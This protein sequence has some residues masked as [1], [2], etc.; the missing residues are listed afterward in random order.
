M[1]PIKVMQRRGIAPENFPANQRQH[2]GDGGTAPLRQS[3]GQLGAALQGA[4]DRVGSVVQEEIDENDQAMV[5][6]AV[7][8]LT[9]IYADHADGPKGYLKKRGLDAMGGH[10]AARKDFD[11]AGLKILTGTGKD[12]MLHNKRQREA[13]EEVFAKQQ[14]AFNAAVNKHMDQEAARVRD[15]SYEALLESATAAAVS[16]G[17]DYAADKQS[18]SKPIWIETIE[19]AVSK[20]AKEMGWSAHTRD[21]EMR[22]R[23]SP[24]NATALDGMVKASRYDD[25]EGY[26]S[27][28]EAA[29]NQLEP[30]QIVKT[31]AAIKE[32]REQTTIKGTAHEMYTWSKELA[33]K[34]QG[35]RDGVVNIE[36]LVD[37]VQ[38]WEIGQVVRPKSQQGEDILGE[39]PGFAF[40]EVKVTRE[41]RD[42]I[43]EELLSIDKRNREAERLQEAD[44][45]AELEIQILETGTYDRRVAAGLGPQGRRTV[46]RLHAAEKRTRK[47]ASQAER[48]FQNQIDRDN[49]EAFKALP[50]KEQA[51]MS[52][53]DIIERFPG[54]SSRGRNIIKQRRNQSGEVW[55]KDKGLSLGAFDDMMDA[56][57]AD[58]GY[59]GTEAAEFKKFAKARYLEWS[60]D[61][62]NLASGTAIPTPK[63]AEDWAV[64]WLTSGTVGAN[65]WWKPNTEKWRQWDA[66]QHGK[67]FVPKRPDNVPS[68]HRFAIGPDG[69]Q[70][71]A[72]AD[73]DLPDGWRWPE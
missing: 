41:I 47:S 14:A 17:V 28:L 65:K 39:G 6:R 38:S 33:E 42:G 55:R 18:W 24:I 72:P 73:T 53:A 50:L 59:F 69:Q 66:I 35:G 27:Y 45:I 1:P 3:I 54:G 26:L 9:S 51:E 21:R 62:K 52:D 46:A 29:G 25:A 71:W 61:P 12:A 11:D 64:D 60:K 44:T 10:I 2:V 70:A 23:M 58:K 13:F 36:D 34:G 63:T 67:V 43:I 5:N 30:A 49:L 20:R 22:K 4:A 15:E 57:V 8:A 48:S 68:T 32:G 16:E 19:S 31:K 56:V 40:P 7:A 37:E